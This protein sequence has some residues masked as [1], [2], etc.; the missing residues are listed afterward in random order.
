ME[1]KILAV[2]DGRTISRNDLD[3]LMM[4]LGQNAMRYANPEGEQILLQELINQ[5]LFYSEAIAAGVDQ[6]DEFKKI[7]EVETRNI[8]KSYAISKLMGSIEVSEAEVAERYEAKKDEFQTPERV[9]ASHI[10]V[11]TEEQAKSIKAE[12]EAGMSFAEAAMTYSKCPS[13]DRGGNLGFFGRGQMVPEFEAASFEL[14]LEVVSEPVGTQFGF[15]LIQVTGKEDSSLM[16]LAEVKDDLK[17]DLAMEKQGAV[18]TDKVNALR[19]QFNV[20]VLI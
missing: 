2:V 3:R 11:D 12:I 18:Y 19:G 9:E 15:H 13:K 14:P 7:I 6:S 4:Q 17:A 8:L 5:E 20:E 10:L 16:S 1:N